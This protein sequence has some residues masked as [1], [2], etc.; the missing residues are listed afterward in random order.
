MKTT[1]TQLFHVGVEVDTCDRIP[2][3]LEMS[4][5]RWVLLKDK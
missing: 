4:L 2:V 5:Q 3:A 1:L